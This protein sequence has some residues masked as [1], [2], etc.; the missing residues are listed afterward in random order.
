MEVLSLSG[1]EVNLP[2]I[3]LLFTLNLYLR[4]ISQNFTTIHV[5]I[6]IKIHKKINNLDIL[7][8]NSIFEISQSKEMLT[9]QHPLNWASFPTPNHHKQ[10]SQMFARP[11][12]HTQL[13]Y[14]H[15]RPTCPSDS[16][17]CSLEVVLCSCCYNS[18]IIRCPSL[19]FRKVAPKPLRTVQQKDSLLC[20]YVKHEEGPFDFN[21]FFWVMMVVIVYWM[22]QDA[23]FRW[24]GALFKF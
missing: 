15:H 8:T 2:A 6:K 16:L 12:N 11:T 7:F 5:L 21:G 9:L 10:G 13:N 18:I 1:F 22:G 19:F 20:F 23:L 4:R 24:G 14:D 17:S 3:C